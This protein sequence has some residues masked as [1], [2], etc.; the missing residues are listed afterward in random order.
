MARADEQED[1]AS[2]PFEP[3]GKLRTRWPEQGG[4]A[5]VCLGTDM[6]VPPGRHIEP[7]FRGQ[8][9][10]DETVSRR[11]KE[12]VR[13]ERR[14]PVRFLPL[15]SSVPRFGLLKARRYRGRCRTLL[16]PLL[17][18]VVV[19]WGARLRRGVVS[20]DTVRNG[21]DVQDVLRRGSIPLGFSDFCPF[22]SPRIC[23]RP[24]SARHRTFRFGGLV[25]FN[26]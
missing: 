3:L 23:L 15:V 1:S 16:R 25:A 6:I 17:R 11:G 7:N 24:S 20:L 14:S 13:T 19:R 4:P 10:T 8:G 12:L 18:T 5:V 22:T 2:Y 9:N 21:H 26:G